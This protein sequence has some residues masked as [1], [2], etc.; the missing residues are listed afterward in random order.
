MSFNKAEII[1]K[2]GDV[3]TDLRFMALNDLIVAIQSDKLEESF[4][5]SDVCLRAP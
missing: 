5:T 4:F 3:D 2:L 1:A